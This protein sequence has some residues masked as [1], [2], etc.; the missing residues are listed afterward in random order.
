M[1]YKLS[2]AGFTFEIASLSLLFSLNHSMALMLSYLVLHGASSVLFALA[3]S[4]VIPG[5]YRRPRRWLLVY[6]AAFN[7]FMPAAGLL[8]TL[9]ALAA[10]I[11]WPKIDEKSKFDTASSPLFVTAG[12]RE[13]SGFRG[14]R[15]RAQL[16]NQN[17]PLDERL[18]ALVAI[19]NAPTRN[20]GEALRNLLTDKSD[21]IRLLAYGILD[22]KE[23]K[24][25]QRIAEARGQLDHV[26]E[27]QPRA[28]LHKQIA[29]LYQELVYQNL[30]Q[31]DLMRYACDQMRDHTQMALMLNPAETGLWF[32]LVRLELMTGNVAAAETA[33]QLAGRNG[34][35]RARLLPYLAELSFLKKDYAAVRALFREISFDASVSAA[36]QLHRYWMR[37]TQ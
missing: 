34:F 9:A 10:G 27:V 22:G 30:V 17:V 14:T 5:R 23:K 21:D 19:Q 18:N 29:E 33:L 36:P 1:L 25:A 24:I 8:C 13:G 7:F 6:L 3:I 26:D 35:P 15:V 2:F 16:R 12:K 37:T 20:S 31:G 4:L 32:M 28:V 11:L